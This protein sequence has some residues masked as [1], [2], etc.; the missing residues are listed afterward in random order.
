MV[1]TAIIGSAVVGAGASVASSSAQSKAASKS[2]DSQMQ[3]YDQTREDLSPYNTAGQGV[4][5]QL[6]NVVSS[7]TQPTYTPVVMDQQSLEQTPGY[8]FN[9]TQGL[10]STQNSAA[11]RGLGTSGA[12]LKGAATYATGLADST[13][14]NQFANAQSNA[15]NVYNSQVA[16]QT[17]QY[18][19]LLGVASLGENAAAQTGTAGTAAANGASQAYTNAGNAQAAGYN[20]AA[21]SVNNGV[22]NYL[23]Y[24]AMKGMYS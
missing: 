4:I 9:L 13:Y 3:M 22:G 18:N 2:A 24:N 7:Q 12:A 23:Q 10:K 16:G 17:N 11:A 20:G 6:S 8:Q 14:Q 5:N 19:R 15:M 1:A 21:A